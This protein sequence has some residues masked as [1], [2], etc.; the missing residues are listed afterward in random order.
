MFLTGISSEGP[1]FSWKEQKLYVVEL[2]YMIIINI[3]YIW[4]EQINLII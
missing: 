3:I 4:F 1:R 2:I